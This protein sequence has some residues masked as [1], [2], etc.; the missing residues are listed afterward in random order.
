MGE[1][2]RSRCLKTIRKYIPIDGKDR[3][4]FM[5]VKKNSAV[6]LLLA[7]ITAILVSC[8][9]GVKSSS[10]QRSSEVSS[11]AS[12]SQAEVSDIIVTDDSKPATD[13]SEKD[14][15]KV[16]PDSGYCAVGKVEKSEKSARIV[17]QNGVKATVNFEDASPKQGGVYAYKKTGVSYTFSEIP[18][19]NGSPVASTNWEFAVYDQS[20]SGVPDIIYTNDGKN[21]HK[22]DF[23]SKSVIFA[24]Y[25]ETQWQIFTGNDL[26]KSSGFPVSGW[27]A[28]E[29]AKDGG[30]LKVTVVVLGKY[31]YDEDKIIGADAGS[32]VYLD[33]EGYGW[34]KGD[35]DLG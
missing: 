3:W 24:R 6:L 13:S 32:T 14:S 5:I 10:S 22:Y 27:F 19:I 4:V 9:S 28:T 30:N 26:I 25:S 16:L 33:S 17:A 2:S 35:I 20:A 21:E 12:S 29:D 15:E 11:R 34:N 18:F 8:G 23:N 1:A 31:D 7:L